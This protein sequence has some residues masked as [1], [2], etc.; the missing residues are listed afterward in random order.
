MVKLCLSFHRRYEEFTDPLVQGLKS[1]LLSPESEDPEVGKKKR[2]QIR[3]VIELYQVGIIIDEDF[4]CQ[5]LRTL[6]GK[7]KKK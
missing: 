7:Q 6:L 4:F 3:F 5:L 2:I 1:S